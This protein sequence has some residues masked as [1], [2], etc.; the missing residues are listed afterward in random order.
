MKKQIDTNNLRLM[1]FDS[2]K[3]LGE[4]VDKH[5]L[6]MYHLD[7]EKDTFIVPIKQ[8]YFEDGHFKVEIEETVRGKDLFLL[9]DIGNYSIEYKMHGFI[10][11]TSPNDIMNQLKDGIGACNCH[12]KTINIVMPLLY[13]GRQHRRNTRENLAC[14]MMLHELDEMSRI[15]GFITFDAHDQGVEHAIHNMEFNNFFPTNTILEQLIQDLPKAKLRKI[16]F[17]APDNGATGRRNVYL[18]SFNSKYIHRE[19]GSFFKQRD[20]NNFVDGKYPVIAHDYCGNNNLE[21]YTAI[22][23]D[24]MISSGSSMFD[25]IEELKKYK[26]KHIIVVVT[27]ALFTKGIDQFKDYVE[28]GMLDGI[29]TTNLSYIPEEYQKEKWLHV[30]DCSEYLAKII[31]SI[32]NDIS[33]TELLR[34]KSLPIRLIEEK[35]EKDS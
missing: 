31:Y 20:Y 26:V 30:C 35:F 25:C 15:K 27:Y 28:K 6:D 8:N 21:G 12:A 2:A 4:K 19:A 17:V 1:V 24:D 7:A 16:V 34:D 13:A 5:L 9:T 3:D 11:H 22:I 32:H 29:Y 18:N 10:N 23:S 33:I 14:G